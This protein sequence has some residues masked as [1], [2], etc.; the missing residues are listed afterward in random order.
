ML[1]GTPFGAA[2]NYRQDVDY[3]TG[4]ATRLIEGKSGTQHELE[5]KK[6]DLLS[7]I[8]SVRDKAI[9][10]QLNL[11]SEKVAA[12]ASKYRTGTNGLEM[13]D[14]PYMFDPETRT[15]LARYGIKAGGGNKPNAAPINPQP[16]GGGAN[17]NQFPVAQ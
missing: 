15:R 11:M 14:N 8:R 6:G 17:W 2:P 12:L 7:P 10:E 1:T 9:K 3:L 5:Q 16:Q 13:A 4:E